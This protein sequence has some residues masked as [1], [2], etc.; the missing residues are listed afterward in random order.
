MMLGSTVSG[1]SIGTNDSP[2][3]SKSIEPNEEYDE[4]WALWLELETNDHPFGNPYNFCT[5]ENESTLACFT[6]TTADPC[7]WEFLVSIATHA[8]AGTFIILSESHWGLRL[9]IPTQPVFSQQ[10]K[11]IHVIWGLM[12]SP[13]R[14]GN[15]V[16]K[17]MKHCSGAE[18]TKEVLGH[19][20]YSSPIHQTLTIPRIMPRMS[21]MLLVR[22]A[23]DRP[24]VIP[25]QTSN[26]G[27]VGQ[28]VEIPRYSCVDI[29]YGIRTAQ[30]ATSQLT[31]ISLPDDEDEDRG[32]TLVN[33]FRILFWK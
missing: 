28:F 5:R 24:G 14:N 1:S 6:T 2:P 23:T 33:L 20:K 22:S 29:S 13:Q 9:C 8:E 26:L 11:D 18:I 16:Q 4:N 15:Y 31:G 12:L 7:L 21:S 17:Q 19:L 27:F 32:S 3:I 10:P 25:P 30:I